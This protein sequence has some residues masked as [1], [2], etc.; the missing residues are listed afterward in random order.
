VRSNSLTRDTKNGDQFSFE[1]AIALDLKN[2]GEP[3]PL[4]LETELMRQGYELPRL[5]RKYSR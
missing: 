4:D 1:M 3:V 5:Y 2:E